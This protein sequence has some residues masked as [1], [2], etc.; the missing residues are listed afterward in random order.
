MEK[1][2]KRRFWDVVWDGLNSEIT[3]KSKRNI[4]VILICIFLISLL[5]AGLKLNGM[6]KYDYNTTYPEDT[7]EYLET[8]ADNAMQNGGF[9][10]NKIPENVKYEFT[11]DGDI[12]LSYIF[13]K[14]SNFL[15]ADV[16]IQ[17]SDNFE[18][19]SKTRNIISSDEFDKNL[20]IAKI[21]LFIIFAITYLVAILMIVM[22]LIV[23]IVI[24]ALIQQCL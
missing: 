11:K 17:V 14:D 5:G 16:K 10:K 6:N 20:K 24:I 15:N 12:N 18:I 23:C 2:E 7:Y 1:K 8:I 3:P 19:K 9:N 13:E 22:I 21:F 4:I